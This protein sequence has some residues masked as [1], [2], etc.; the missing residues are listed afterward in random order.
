MGQQVRCHERAIAVP[1]NTNAI[2][3]G[4]AHLR[5]FVD[6]C[7]RTH[8]DLFDVGI[9]D[10]LRRADDRHRCV[11]EHGITFQQ[12]EQVRWPNNGRRALS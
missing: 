11:I 12:K 9:V 7:L 2:G 6:R 4:N 1:A 10:G 5:R 3:I 8:H